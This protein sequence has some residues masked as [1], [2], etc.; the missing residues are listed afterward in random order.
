[1]KRDR[2]KYIISAAAV[3]A[4][5]L[6]LPG[7]AASPTSEY[8]RLGGITVKGV[9]SGSL[10]DMGTILSEKL[11]EDGCAVELQFCGDTWSTQAV[12]MRSLVANRASCIAAVLVDGSKE[13]LSGSFSAAKAA[14][15]PVVIIDS[16]K[17]LSD[18]AGTAEEAYQEIKEY[19]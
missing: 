19:L 1:M 4:V 16:E 8:N 18:P 11:K 15:I 17:A 13:D 12:Q 5:L 10:Y 3:L 2:R 7:C 14:G 6:L 9:S